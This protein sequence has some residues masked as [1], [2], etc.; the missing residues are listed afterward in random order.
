MNER[1][2]EGR[3]LF[4]LW[5]GVLWFG[6]SCELVVPT[7]SF[8]PQAPL[9]QQAKGSLQG[10]LV[11]QDGVVG[12]ER[13]GERAA[14][15]DIT[16]SLRDENG[17]PVEQGG[18]VVDRALVDID[19]DFAVDQGRGA[20]RFGDLTPGTYTVVFEGIPASYGAVGSV[21]A[22]M[23][24]GESV[25]VGELA[26]TYAVDDAGAGPYV[27]EGALTSEG[28]GA[29]P[30]TV[31]LFSVDQD[32]VVR[33]EK[34]VAG[35]DGFRFDGLF[36]GTYA[37]L[38]KG[39]GEMPAY[40]LDVPV[41]ASS[42][43]TSFAG[44]QAIALHPVTAVLLPVTSGPGAVQTI[45]GENYV[46][47]EPV[48]L[49]VLSF[50]PDATAS[51]GITTMRLSTDPDFLDDA[52]VALPFSP[53][54]A[55]ASVALPDHDGRHTIHAQ[56]Q[57]GSPAGFA[58]LSP[59]FSIDVIKD[60]V[61]PQ[62]VSAT[63]PGLMTVLTED[64]VDVCLSPSRDVLLR[65]T[66][67]DDTSALASFGIGV[68]GVPDDRTQLVASPGSVVLERNVTV[69]DDGDHALLIVTSDRAGNDTML[70][71]HRMHVLVDTVGPAVLLSIDNAVGG[72]L[73]EGVA[74]LRV[75]STEPSDENLLAGFG[76]EG[77]LIEPDTPFVSEP[78]QEPDALA[79]HVARATLPLPGDARPG[80][81]FTFEAVVTDV[82]GNTTRVTQTINLP[83]AP[84]LPQV[85]INGGADVTHQKEVQVRLSAVDFSAVCVSAPG[86][87]TCFSA[88]DVAQEIPILLETQDGTAVVVATF[89][90]A[91]GNSVSASD[92]I[93]IDTQEPSLSTPLLVN[94]AA[95]G[96]A[97]SVSAT[98][99]VRAAGADELAF[100]VVDGGVP[101]DIDLLGLTYQPYALDNI[102]LL[103]AGDGD[104]TVCVVLRDRAGNVFEPLTHADEAC[105]TTTLDTTAPASP[106]I[107]SA[108]GQVQKTPADRRFSL[109]LAALD[110]DVVQLAVSVEGPFGTLPTERFDVA[111]DRTYAVPVR[112]DTTPGTDPS[113]RH[114]LRVTAVDAAGNES[115]EATLVVVYDDDPPRRPTIAD[116]DVAA[117]ALAGDI[118]FFPR[119][120]RA[121]VAQARPPKFNSDSFAVRI[122][123]RTN[124]LVTFAGNVD[125]SIDENFDHFEIAR[126][127]G[128]RR[129]GDALVTRTPLDGLREN[130]TSDLSSP[131]RPDP[132]DLPYTEVAGTDSLIVPL[133]QGA[134][135]N[136]S[137][138][139]G[140][141][142]TPRA[143]LN[144]LFLR[145]VDKAGNV[146]LAIRIDLVE[147]SGPPTKPTLSPREGAMVGEQ[148]VLRLQERSFDDSDFCATNNDCLE[149]AVCD[150]VKFSCVSAEQTDGVAVFAYEL[151]EGTEGAFGGVPAGQPV[152]GPWSLRLVPGE[153]NTLCARGVDEAGNVGIEDCATVQERS[154]TARL[155][156]ASV[157]ERGPRLA[158]DYLV[159]R[160]EDRLVIDDL[161]APPPSSTDDHVVL[162]EMFP[163]RSSGGFDGVGLDLGVVADQGFDFLTVAA[164]SSVQDVDVV[165]VRY[166]IASSPPPL[167]M[168]PVTSLSTQRSFRGFAPSVL[169][170]DM[171][172]SCRNGATTQILR[173]AVDALWGA[174]R[175]AQGVEVSLP[176]IVAGSVRQQP[177]TAYAS[178]PSQTNPTLFSV[179][180]T[181]PAGRQLCPGTAPES[182][183]ATIAVPAVVWCETDSEGSLTGAEI[184][185]KTAT[186][187]AVRLG[188]AALAFAGALADDGVARAIRPLASRSR[189][190][191]VDGDSQTIHT[192]RLVPGASATDTGIEANDLYDLD[193]DDVVF[194]RVRTDGLT[195]DLFLARLG[196]V[197]PQEVQ[198]TDDLPPDGDGTLSA[199]RMAVTALASRG[200][201]IDLRQLRDDRFLASNDTFRFLPAV[202]NERAAWVELRDG[203]LALVSAAFREGGEA[204]VLS[205]GALL[206][207]LSFVGG[208]YLGNTP[209]DVG[210]GTVG[211][212]VK[213]DDPQNPTSWTASFFQVSGSSSTLMGSVEGLASAAGPG[214]SEATLAWDIDGGGSV[215]GYINARTG[216]LEV[217]TLENLDAPP[218]LSVPSGIGPDDD[219]L[220]P[221]LSVDHTAT[222]G[223]TTAVWQW[224]NGQGDGPGAGDFR[225]DRMGRLQYAHRRATQVV[226]GS[227]RSST[228][229]IVVGRSPSLAQV[230]ARVFVAWQ[231]VSPVDGG[232]AISRTKLC[233]VVVA[234]QGPQ[235]LDE[236]LLDNPLVA[237]GRSGAPVV[238]RA[239][240]VAWPN[241]VARPTPQIDVYDIDQRL[242]VS[243]TATLGDGLAR[244]AVVAAGNAIVWLD[245]RLGTSD[246]WYAA[247]P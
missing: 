33:F 85:L 205:G 152:G 126:T 212:A 43:Q 2:R 184:R 217:K 83:P 191:W 62:V 50:A 116:A 45:A 223:F 99:R 100:V 101:E 16:V 72:L 69:A 71:P 15:W 144:H 247:Y 41:S 174:L 141:H 8:D 117:S 232:G 127:V 231:V 54:T 26:L 84:S 154:V 97:T 89:L 246:V 86:V 28:A 119:Q 207:R 146:G 131:L 147:D 156:L 61:A 136:G 215:V 128:S 103:P 114:L 34:S 192:V 1:R 53:Y 92:S 158:G 163:P 79:L 138:N 201:D 14:L 241:G 155:A 214:R 165:Q 17:R 47:Q 166:G 218:L 168:D 238:S 24:P 160:V 242:R 157:S 134:P 107:E 175:N 236:V 48:P 78:S 244:E 5:V 197:P 162:E 170:S 91:L 46:R 27:I 161:G 200:E 12:D 226:T 195:N 6:T 229:T 112:G 70:A 203:A 31:E 96:F 68:D 149:N 224:G 55:T 3:S 137:G 35:L 182:S 59:T 36:P 39:D 58:F 233:E 178:C 239:G 40:R 240:F 151:K 219:E 10:A 187:A 159:Y 98:A 211:A 42:P 196:T 189:L 87:A 90:D 186:L 76:F 109:R 19:E 193:G 108:D 38:V 140:L 121:G 194:A 67:Q 111:Q 80:G 104:K 130:G 180:A 82:V 113:T 235:C 32:R 172:F 122:S 142:C 208:A 213:V 51:V 63:C 204:V 177:F 23:G 150:G 234:A 176:G 190:V 245:G 120:G 66:V 227:L 209:V 64:G 115:N 124:D 206:D 133:V 132:T 167:V 52:A 118:V 65:T 145:A 153:Q 202:S 37:V 57:A 228:G 221:F 198:L 9:D 94:G 139:L 49:A 74:E 125:A 29:G 173:V 56:F 18:Q 73:S 25:D 181:L 106:V 222:D 105:V 237:G 102:V 4:T 143:C 169:G 210:G 93:D 44:D 11:L 20:F 30:R 148:A 88:A 185:A 81:S 171:T 95:D 13:V 135:L 243:L 220:V 230:G 60:T 129:V 123:R 216:D 199:G 7:N 75:V 21:V 188:P 183:P 179:L 110:D 225:R 164:Q 22:V 77:Q